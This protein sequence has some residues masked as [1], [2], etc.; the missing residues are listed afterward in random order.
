MEND[1]V[2]DR[3]SAAREELSSASFIRVTAREVAKIGECNWKDVLRQTVEKS[4][5]A[6]LGLGWKN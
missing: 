1:F 3:C 5:A 4:P 6:L 2:G